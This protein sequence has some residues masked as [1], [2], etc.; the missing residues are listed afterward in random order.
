MA[1]LH[2]SLIKYHGH[3]NSATILIDGKWSC[4]VI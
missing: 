1:Y 3:L 2:K 4:K